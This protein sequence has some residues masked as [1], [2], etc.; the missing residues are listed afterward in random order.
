[1]SRVPHLFRLDFIP[2]EGIAIVVPILAHPPRSL[3]LRQ[4]DG[5]QHIL[6]P[7]HEFVLPPIGRRYPNHDEEVCVT[8]SSE[9]GSD[10]V[11]L[12]LS[13]ALQFHRKTWIAINGE[14][15]PLNNL[16]IQHNSRNECRGSLV[17]RD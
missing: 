14:F 7:G 5:R 17:Q 6:E 13:P 4:C 12:T 10:D 1:M 9:D 3:R 8:G 16:D 2:G 11:I 15:A